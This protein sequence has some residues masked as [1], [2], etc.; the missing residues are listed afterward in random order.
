MDDL[1]SFED[2]IVQPYN[3]YFNLEKELYEVK[4]KLSLMEQHLKYLE[5]KIGYRC[6]GNLTLEERIE[7]LDIKYE[8]KEKDNV[9]IYNDIKCIKDR[10]D[11]L[12]YNEE[13]EEPK[14][15][16]T[17]NI[18]TPSLPSISINSSGITDDIILKYKNIDMLTI[19][20][21]NDICC[22]DLLKILKSLKVLRLFIYSAPKMQSLINLLMIH[23][24]K[25]SYLQI[26]NNIPD[27]EIKNLQRYCYYNH[28]EL[29]LI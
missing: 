1:I 17:K 13:N 10:L 23:N 2:L 24:I 22:Y 7:V 5:N 9:K 21:N 4:S 3:S 26:E 18:E 27:Y 28:I 25:V 8:D 6:K 12:E 19:N 14:K 11:C 15:V 29:E 16:S 20:L